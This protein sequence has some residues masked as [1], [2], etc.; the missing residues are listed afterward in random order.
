[1]KYSAG[2]LLVRRRNHGPEVFLVRPGGPFWQHKDL[3]AWGMPKGV[4]DDG[5]NPQECA[6]REFAEEIGISLPDGIEMTAIEPFRQ[7]SYKTIYPY[8]VEW[9]VEI[10]EVHSN[11]TPEGF[12]EIDRGEWF[13]FKTARAKIMPGQMRL[14]EELE[15]RF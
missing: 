12:P 13:D 15:D 14:I 2:V 11:L 4:I 5:E 9:D 7:S 10:D 6:K 3:G 1:M 8:I